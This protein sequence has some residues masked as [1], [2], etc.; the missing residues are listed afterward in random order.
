MITI[1][2]DPTYERVAGLELREKRGCGICWWRRM[3][4]VGG[5]KCSIGKSF[6]A[7]QEDKKGFTIDMGRAA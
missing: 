4:V 3:Q 2:R 7:C 6:D 1:H 5:V